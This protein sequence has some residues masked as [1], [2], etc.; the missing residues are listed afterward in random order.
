MKERYRLRTRPLS[1][2]AN[3]ITGENYRI[4]VLTEG[5]IRLEYDRDAEFED[6]GSQMALYR[7]LPFGSVREECAG[8]FGAA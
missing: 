2:E 6:R 4:T 7:D 5:L 1:P 8:P 3:R